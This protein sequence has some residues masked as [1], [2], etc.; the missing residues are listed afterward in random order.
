MGGKYIQ[1]REREGKGYGPDKSPSWTSRKT[2]SHK[3]IKVDRRRSHTLVFSSYL[4]L[5][6]PKSPFRFSD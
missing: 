2:T 3:G 6:L 4:H 1:E 5:S